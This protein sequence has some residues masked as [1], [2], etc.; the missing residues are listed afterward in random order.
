MENTPSPRLNTIKSKIENSSEV[1]FKKYNKH[2]TY[3]KQFK[4]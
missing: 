1:I 3:C 4:I 2:S